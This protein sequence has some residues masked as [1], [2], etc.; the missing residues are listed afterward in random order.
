MAPLSTPGF[1]LAKKVSRT[2][3]KLDNAPRLC[4][5]I[6]RRWS[7]AVSSHDFQ[8][9]PASKQWQHIFIINRFV[10]SKFISQ[11]QYTGDPLTYTMLS[12]DVSRPLEKASSWIYYSGLNLGWLSVPAMSSRQWLVVPGDLPL[13]LLL[14]PVDLLGYR[15]SADT[16]YTAL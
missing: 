4:I 10:C 12:A 14:P 5:L 3:Y 13:L 8:R 2:G 9:K 1:I 7:W 6:I 16:W 11:H 15:R